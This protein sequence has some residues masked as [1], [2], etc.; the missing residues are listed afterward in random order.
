MPATL[1]PNFLTPPPTEEK[2]PKLQCNFFHNWVDSTDSRP[3]NLAI[4]TPEQ[5]VGYEQS[6]LRERPKYIPMKSEKIAKLSPEDRQEYENSLNIQKTPK[7]YA[8][9]LTVVNFVK[10][11]KLL[12]KFL[13]AKHA[14]SQACMHPSVAN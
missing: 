3:H 14:C 10:Q 1:K 9:K 2:R 12:C 7:R 13:P 5:R 6:L 4:M 8:L 11:L